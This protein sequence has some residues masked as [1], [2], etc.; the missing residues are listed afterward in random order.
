MMTMNDMPGRATRRNSGTEEDR[1][2]ILKMVE[3]GTITAAEASTLLDAL[4]EADQSI[5]PPE[6][7]ARR[8]GT[9]SHVRIRITDVK[10]GRSNVN[11][12][13]PIGLL[14]MGL[15]VVR[16][17]VPNADNNMGVIRDALSSGNLGP[18]VSVEDDGERV[19][20]IAE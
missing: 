3:S 15:G 13:L 8:K 7:P 14:D 10:S 16:R 6:S 2:E 9:V 20:I 5:V 19:E 11:V 17:F 18:I 12:V 1:I 4:D